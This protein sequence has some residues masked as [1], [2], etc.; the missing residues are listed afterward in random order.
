M[1][2]W[3]APILATALAAAPLPQSQTPRDYA[4]TFPL[5]LPTADSGNAWRIELTPAVYAHV[6]D[7]ALRDL[8]VFNADGHAVPVA[9]EDDAPDHSRSERL[10]AVPVLPL[11]AASPALDGDLRLIVERDADGRLRRLDASQSA[12]ATPQAASGD[13]LLDAS[14]LDGSIERLVLDWDAPDEGVVAHFDLAASD[15]LQHWHPLGSASVFALRQDSARLDRREIALDSPRARYLRLH[16]TDSG[17]ALQGLRARLRHVQYTTTAVPAPQWLTATPQPASATTAAGLD[18]DYLLPARLPIER[19][20][21]ELAT[22]NAVADLTLLDA[23]RTPGVP[24][25]QFTAF[26]LRSGEEQLRNDAIALASRTPLQR[27]RLQSHT[28]LTAAPRVEIA[29]RPERLVF[30]AE[31]RAPYTLAVGSARVQRAQYPIE[32]ALAGLRARLGAQWQPPL[33]RIGDGQV[34]GGEAVL[35]TAP[36][37]MAWQR[38]VLWVTLIAAAMLVGGLALSLLRTSRR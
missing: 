33:A 6:H 32:A 37:A 34:S 4:W 2:G 17:T 27:L 8:A 7:P 13:Y 1:N 22:D 15:D 28:P 38:G 24:L 18:F 14:A 5:Q 31:G 36:A 25:A 12:V 35:Q 16:R 30:L 9:R 19:V 10:D 11:P 29:F 20:R 23:D 21:V 3:I 26:R